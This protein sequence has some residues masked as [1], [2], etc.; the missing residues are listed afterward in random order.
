MVALNPG[1]I[2][3]TL[4]D[5]G[6]HTRF[7]RNLVFQDCWVIDLFAR[8]VSTDQYVFLPVHIFEGQSQVIPKQILRLPFV[9]VSQSVRHI[10]SES[11]T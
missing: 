1:C 7:D 10:G 4:D 11:I 8:H 5:E 3:S 9:R 2:P 6:A